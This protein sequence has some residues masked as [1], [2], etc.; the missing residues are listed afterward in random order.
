MLELNFFERMIAGISPRMALNRYMARQALDVALAYDGASRGR[1]MAEWTKVS[2]SSAN[3]EARPAISILRERSRDLARNNVYGLRAIS[4]ITNSMI[5]GGIRPVFKANGK[6]KA[7]KLNDL[8]QAWGEDDVQADSDGQGNIYALQGLIARTVA[9]SGECIVLRRYVKDPSKLI[10]LEIQVLEPDHIDSSRDSYWRKLGQ[11]FSCLGIE[12]DAQG[13]RSGY[14]LYDV[15]PGECVA[16]EP[17]KLHPA[18]GVI[19]VYRRDRPG[20]IRG[21]PWLAPCVLRLKDLDDYED[22]QLLRQ[23]IAACFCAFVTDTDVVSTNGV[24]DEDDEFGR[25]EPGRIDKLPP[26]K[27]IAFASPPGAENYDSYTRQ[28]LRGI[29]VGTGLTYEMLSGDYSQVNFTS[30]RMGKGDFWPC[31]DVWQWQ[32][33]APQALSK[34]GRWFLEAAELAGYDTKGVRI[35]WV[36]PRRELVDP[37]KE[38]PAMTKYVRSGFTSRQQIIRELGYDPAVVS[39]EI[40]EDN[41]LADE[42]GLVLDSDARRT[43]NSGQAQAGKTAENEGDDN[44]DG[45]E[46]NGTEDE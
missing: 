9:E 14:W 6:A 45:E 30:G 8:W 19:H 25:L 38:I 22:A 40:A 7:Q 18:D 35:E 24:S 13:H 36:P 23:K 31:L 42:L 26:G 39:A 32:M 27:A 12:F 20:Q 46:T 33:F 37:T 11:P 16:L 17:S 15:H 2:G 43:N 28:V 41:K 29:A 44:G 1:R 4:I 5:G 34:I 10:P 21:I 3:T